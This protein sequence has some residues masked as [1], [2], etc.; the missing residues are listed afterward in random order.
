MQTNNTPGLLGML[1]ALPTWLLMQIA[2]PVLPVKHPWKAS[3]PSLYNWALHE[4]HLCRQFD[5]LLWMSFIMT[6]WLITALW[7]R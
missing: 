4:T 3:A 1:L 2:R 6:A 5:V 7:L